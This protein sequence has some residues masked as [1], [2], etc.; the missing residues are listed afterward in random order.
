MNKNIKVPIKIPPID[1]TNRFISPIS[2]KPITF[3]H[4]NSILS[5]LLW[6]CD[7][8]P[9]ASPHIEKNIVENPKLGLNNIMPQV[10]SIPHIALPDMPY[11][12]EQHSIDTTP[13]TIPTFTFQISTEQN[14]DIKRAYATDKDITLSVFI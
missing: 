10:E 3:I 1:T 5:I 2:I 9:Q 4:I 11:I 13:K 6:L 8:T 14:V 7:R 12:L